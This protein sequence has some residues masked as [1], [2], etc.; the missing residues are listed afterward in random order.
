MESP[1]RRI[2]TEKGTQT[3]E[4]PWK[5]DGKTMEIHITSILDI[6]CSNL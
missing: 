2:S 3:M 5:N 6:F 4:K 1:A